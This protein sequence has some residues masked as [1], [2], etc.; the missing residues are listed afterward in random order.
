MK[1]KCLIIANTYNAESHALSDKVADFLLKRDIACELFLFSGREQLLQC[2]SDFD[3]AVTLGGDGTVLFA[4][5][6][7]APHGI[8]IFAINL[9]LF[10][11][12]AGVQKTDWQL[13]LE[14]FLCGTVPAAA[15]SMLCGCVYRGGHCVFES[16]AL[17]D[18]VVSSMTAVS[19]ISVDVSYNTIPFGL[20]KA[21]GVIV[22]TSTGST[23]YSA[24]A[25]GPIIDPALDVIVLSPICA[26]SLSNRPVVLPA[27]G[28]L[29]LH[30][31]PSRDSGIVCK[32]D[33]QVAYEL[34]PDDVVQITIAAYK[35]LL[36]DCSRQ[37][38]YGAL[39]SKLHWSGGINA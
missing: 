23:S 25:G 10:G 5:R 30:V 12:I 33:G 18:F 2:C 35:A 28:M 39:R 27:D 29:S 14:Q 16:I 19:L 24:A 20:F 11:F 13:S 38:F 31:L 17:N 8:P 36:V 15:R 3:F 7:C 1:K 34:E 22:A 32:A 6:V 4:A 37:K 21:D 26:F 9:G